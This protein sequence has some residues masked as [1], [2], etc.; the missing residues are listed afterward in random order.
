MH[1]G[2]KNINFSNSGSSIPQLTVPMV[3]G[4]SIPF[5]KSISEQKQLAHQLDD[6]KSQTQV[7]ESNF[8]QKIDAL[9]ELKISILQK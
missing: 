7:L 8:Q 3:K 1:Y 4:Y 6:L 9:D 5:P 2:L